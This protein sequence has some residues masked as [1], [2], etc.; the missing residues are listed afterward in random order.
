LGNLAHRALAHWECLA[1]PDEE[2]QA[3]LI[4]WARRG[5]LV[6]S[7]DVA[8]AVSRVSRMLTVLRSTALYRE[9][10]TAQE[11]HVEV[12]FSIRAGD[13]TLHGVLDM[14]YRHR[15][16]EWWLLDWKTESLRK[17]Q[18]LQ[19][20]ATSYLQQVAVYGRAVEQLLGIRARSEICFLAADA[21]LY[22]P[23]EDELA[24]AWNALL[25]Q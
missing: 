25:T 2:L 1:A 11:R 24:R 18:S 3:L 17:G 10:S 16:G 4:Q 19:D 6:E 20:A 8:A 5:G 15:N 13:Q 22:Y 7:G 12:P 23:T 9:V 14:L 21:T